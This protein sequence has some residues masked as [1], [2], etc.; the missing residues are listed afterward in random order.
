[1]ISGFAVE[2]GCFQQGPEVELSSLT[3][4]R[5]PS[6]WTCWHSW[7]KPPHLQKMLAQA[8][9]GT[10]LSWKHELSFPH[11]TEDFGCEK[12][13]RSAVKSLILML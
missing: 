11:G 13:R 12:T 8:R 2:A 1:M 6:T 10:E 5:N 7:S 4:G 9:V 3:E